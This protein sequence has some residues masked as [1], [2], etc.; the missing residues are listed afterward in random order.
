MGNLV[1]LNW[2]GYK[3]YTYKFTGHEQPGDYIEILVK[4]IMSY[5]EFEAQKADQEQLLPGWSLTNKWTT[6]HPYKVSTVQY[7]MDFITTVD[8]HIATESIRQEQTQYTNKYADIPVSQT[9]ERHVCPISQSIMQDP[10]ITSCGHTFEE[11]YIKQWLTNNNSCPTCKNKINNNLT[12]N[13]V[14][15]GIIDDKYGSQCNN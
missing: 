1:P 14:L 2:Q 5:K 10:V 6:Q 15:K 7:R 13:Y 11:Y 12:T 3:L 9:D 4:P 8:Q